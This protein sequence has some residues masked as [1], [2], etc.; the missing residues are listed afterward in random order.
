[1]LSSQEFKTFEEANKYAAPKVDNIDKVW[2]RGINVQD[3][4][5][6]YSYLYKPSTYSYNHLNT[7]L[8]H[9]ESVMRVLSH[10][11][12]HF[13]GYSHGMSMSIHEKMIIQCARGAGPC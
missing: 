4:V 5:N 13:L 11:T 6:N 1:M 10:E 9:T 8:T 12:S 7:I 2:L 3:G